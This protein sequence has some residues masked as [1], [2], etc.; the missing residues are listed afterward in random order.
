MPSLDDQVVGRLSKADNGE[1][2]DVG[3]EQVRGVHRGLDPHDRPLALGIGHLLNAAGKL[4]I[5][6]PLRWVY[7]TTML[8]EARVAPEV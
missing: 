3:A 6:C 5:A 2:G 7:G 4:R 1:F 8:G